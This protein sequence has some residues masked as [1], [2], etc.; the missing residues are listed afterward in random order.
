M[1]NMLIEAAH[2]GPLD[3]PNIEDEEERKKDAIVFQGKQFETLPKLR[4][5]SQYLFST[6]KYIHT[7]HP[8]PRFDN[9]AE[10]GFYLNPWDMNGGN[11]LINSPDTS[12]VTA[13]IDWEMVP[14]ESATVM[15]F[16]VVLIQ[17]PPIG[18][19]GNTSSATFTTYRPEPNMKYN[20]REARVWYA[21]SR[22][23]ER[24]KYVLEE[25]DNLSKSPD[26]Q[27][28]DV[29]E[30]MWI[31]EGDKNKEKERN[32]IESRKQGACNKR[33]NNEFNDEGRNDECND[34]CNGDCNNN[35]ECITKD[36]EEKGGTCNSGREE[37]E[38][39]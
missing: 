24:E 20:K 15:D 8:G 10:D 16:D 7:N 11:P 22:K 21:M 39:R 6:K 13:W 14:T 23:A 9:P 30:K 19:R 17:E 26:I 29:Y 3:D 5:L 18:I 37:E 38:A 25:R 2:L 35:G 32:K 27:I 36:R 12:N 1:V 28:F 34:E 4:D 33:S 31:K